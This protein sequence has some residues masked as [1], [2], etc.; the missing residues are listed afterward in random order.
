MKCVTL[1]VAEAAAVLGISRSTA[2]EAVRVGQIP[3]LT[4]GKR[5]VVPLAALETITGAK[6][7]HRQIS[8]ANQ[9]EEVGKWH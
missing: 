8:V 5:I 4:F 9:V 3:A 1:T 7:N 2:Y 6:L